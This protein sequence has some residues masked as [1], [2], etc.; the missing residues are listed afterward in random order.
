V[1]S[2]GTISPTGFDLEK[3]V[4]FVIVP[5]PATALD[6]TKQTNGAAV[7]YTAAASGG[8]GPYLYQFWLKDTTGIYTLVQSYSSSNILNWDTTGLPAGTYFIAVQAKSSGSALPNGFDVEN[9]VS[10]VIP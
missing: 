8:S 7:T 5:F 10:H 1:K 6:I 3:V 2:A 4:N 9:V